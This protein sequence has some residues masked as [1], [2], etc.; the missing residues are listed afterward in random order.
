MHFQSDWL[1][2]DPA[3]HFNP[4]VDIPLDTAPVENDWATHCQL[5]FRLQ[6]IVH[7]DIPSIEF[8]VARQY[9]C[10]RRKSSF[11]FGEASDK[12]MKIPAFGWRKAANI[13]DDAHSSSNG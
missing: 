2:A 9:G 3:H 13:I 5:F 10:Y 7:D 4:E 1:F 8:V 11:A 6:E 12:P